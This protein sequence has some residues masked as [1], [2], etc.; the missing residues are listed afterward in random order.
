MKMWY[1]KYLWC[2]TTEADAPYLLI[3]VYKMQGQFCFGFVNWL[4]FDILNVNNLFFFL[5]FYRG[6]CTSSFFLCTAYSIFNKNLGKTDKLNSSVALVAKSDNAD[7]PVSVSLM[8]FP[9]PVPGSRVPPNNLPSH[10]NPP[11]ILIFS[12]YTPLFCGLKNLF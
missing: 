1:R 11:S 7:V 5:F 3:T 10:K 9:T 2:E 12:L 8:D 6:S 4:L